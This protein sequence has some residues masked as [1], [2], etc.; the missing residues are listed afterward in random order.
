[1]GHPRVP[2][3][4]PHQLPQHTRGLGQRARRLDRAADD[5]E[6]ADK[7]HNEELSDDAEP[8]RRRDEANDELRTALVEVKRTIAVLFGDETVGVFKLPAELPQ[9]PAALRRV[10]ED[11]SDALGKKPLPKAKIDGIKAVDASSWKARLDKPIAAL[12]GASKD[13]AREEKEAAVTLVAKN[14]ALATFERTFGAAA[15]AG[16][17][18]LTAAGEKEHAERIS[19]TPRRHSA[20]GAGA[21]E[22]EAGAASTPAEPEQK[23]PA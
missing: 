1:M 8:R 11:V 3:A 7:A 19:L 6:S 18:L 15:G 2:H 14:R 5:L 10:G 16:W 17:G 21:A 12:D 22:A 13:V 9:D 4:R 23:Q 20:S